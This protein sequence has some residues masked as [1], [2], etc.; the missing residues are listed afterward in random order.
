[1]ST[2]TIAAGEYTECVVVSPD[3]T[4]VYATNEVTGDISQYA[5][6]T[7]TG[8]L[9]AQPVPTIATEAGPEGIAMSADGEEP[10]RREPRI[11]ERLAI[12]TCF[13]AGRRHRLSRHGG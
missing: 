7:E 1:M 4:D 13:A 8:A 5:R 12:R 9:A 2:A 3:G 10:L 6:N 11:R